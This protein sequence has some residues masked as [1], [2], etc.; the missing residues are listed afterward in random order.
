MTDTEMFFL[1][2]VYFSFPQ[3]KGGPKKCFAFEKHVWLSGAQ[4]SSSNYCVRSFLARAA[5]IQTIVLVPTDVGLVELSSVRSLGE[6]LEF[7]KFIR[8]L[9]SSQT[10][11]RF[12]VEF[13][14]FILEDWIFFF[15]SG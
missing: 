13:E 8:S 14:L 1:A 2:S 10:S 12:F 6:C 7:L 3:G 4:N 11:L 5:G 15:F 9:F